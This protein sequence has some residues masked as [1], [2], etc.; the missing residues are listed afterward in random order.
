LIGILFCDGS[1]IAKIKV[2]AKLIFVEENNTNRTQSTES[3]E[4]TPSPCRLPKLPLK[5]V[6][7]TPVD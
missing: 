3:E 1:R 5:K 2:L 4:Q 6:Y 7:S